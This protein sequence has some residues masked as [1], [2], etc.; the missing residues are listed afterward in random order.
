MADTFKLGDVVRLKSG[1]PAMTVVGL[2]GGGGVC[3]AW[4]D[5]TTLMRHTSGPDMFPHDALERTNP[6]AKQSPE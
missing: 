3:V 1:G 6:D 4:F 2:V 5:G